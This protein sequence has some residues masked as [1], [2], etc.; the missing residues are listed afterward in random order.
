MRR[1]AR[2]GTLAAIAL[3]LTGPTAGAVAQTPDTLPAAERIWI[4][5]K[6]LEGVR[7]HFA[8]WEAVPD[9]DLDAAFRDYAAQIAATSDRRAFDLATMEF[10]AKLRNGHTGFFDQRLRE[11][12]AGPLGFTLTRIEGTW[13]VRESR[14]DGLEPGDAVR[15]INRRPVSGLLADLL[16]YV[17]ASSEAAAVRRVW[18]QTWLW[19]RRLRL[20]LAEGR[21]VEVLRG[22]QELRPVKS[23]AYEEEVLEG[24]IAFL[25]IPHFETPAMEDTAIAF[26]EAHADAP[27]LVIDVRR[28]GGGTTPTRLT[29]ALMDR[30][31][32]GFATSTAFD[33][34][35]YSAYHGI[36]E[37]YPPS[38]FDD[39]TR[40][41]VEAFSEF[42]RPRLVFPAIEERPDRPVYDGPVWILTDDGC[43]SACEDFVLPFKTSGRARI[44]GTPT[45]GSTGQPWLWSFGNGMSVRVSAR[46]AYFPDGSQFEGVGIV[47]DE[48]IPPT[49]ESLREET[50]PVL[51]RALEEARAA[52]R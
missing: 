32:R 13:V 46:R 26:L 2:A 19:P 35:L 39:Y 23:R 3:L 40:G 25:R 50:D 41:Y 27:A 17:S 44:L 43:V 7:T 48:E 45:S 9:L 24:G 11:T 42:D 33:I 21:L 28:N 8:H 10:L 47:P 4:A 20:G 29:R 31:W 51:A 37:S 36:Y 52:R 15:T 38:A 49:I 6:I 12:D 30:P 18:Y 5:A 1:G 16:P 34:G 22:E 14:L